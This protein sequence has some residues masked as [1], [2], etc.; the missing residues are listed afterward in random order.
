MENVDQNIDFKKIVDE[1]VKKMGKANIII[2]GKTGVGKSTLINAVFH[3]KMAQ[4]GVGKPITPNIKEYTKDGVPL[5]IYDTRG[6]ELDNFSAIADNIFGLVNSKKTDNPQDH[7]VLAWYCIN[8]FSKRIE[9]EEIN[10]IK[11]LDS[12]GLKVIVVFT[13]T[14]FKSDK[15][16]YE[17]VK[18]YLFDTG[19][20]LARVLAEPFSE[21]EEGIVFNPWGLNE[22][23]DMSLQ[24]LPE[25][26]KN[27]FAAAQ[28]I[29]I[30]QKVSRSHGVV[31]AAATAAIG[32]GAS[33]IPFS[34][35]FVL[36]PIQ[37][38]MLAG[39]SATMGL[40]LDRGFLST[41]VTSAAGVSGATYLGKTIV[42]NIIKLFP[43][44]GSL[45]GGAISATTAGALTTAMGEAYI[46]AIKYILQ[47]N[48]SG[49]IN[50]EELATVFR[51]KMR[52]TKL[53]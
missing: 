8:N 29:S 42:A 46:A 1:A 39:I 45:V 20:Q 11:R 43:G 10:F 31:A 27:A 12:M 48:N 17:I 9:D 3:E 51:E 23:V 22:L 44:A 50:P 6:L 19:V 13:Q 15:E 5:R 37:V 52:G 36:A 21:E 24:L 38:G 30:D 25:A 16:F 40:S 35:A 47:Q 41:L 32:T 34:D 2:A 7:I 18:G 49:D 26:Q 4:T 33:P 53:S 28:K 14:I